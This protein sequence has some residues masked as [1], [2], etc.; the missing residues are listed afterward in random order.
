MKIPILEGTYVRL[1]PLEVKYIEEL[2]QCSR[3]EEV[4][5]NLPIKINTLDEMKGFV[6]EALMLNEQGDQHPF[7][8]IDKRTNKSV[9]MTRFLRISEGDKTINIG[10]TWYSKKV[11]RT[12][13]NTECKYLLIKHAFEKWKAVRIE[14]I[15]TTEHI[16][17]QK[18]IERIGAK[19][20]GILRKKYRNQDYA[21]Y[22]IINEEWLDIKIRLEGLLAGAGNDI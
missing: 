5:E 1:A 16:K 12:A 22:S 6:E 9:G 17:S 10:W 2:Y 11:W 19:R 21:V 13:I 14:L 8:V 20:E 3:D 15:T 18:A 4:W 7:V